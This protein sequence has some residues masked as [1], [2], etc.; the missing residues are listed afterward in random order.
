MSNPCP[1]PSCGHEAP[2]SAKFCPTC[3][4]RF[5][6]CGQC[7]SI[8][9]TLAKFCRRCGKPIG[10]SSEWPSTR[11]DYEFTAYVPFSTEFDA[12][13]AGDAL[14]APWPA[15]AGPAGHVYTSPVS[16]HGLLII[17][18]SKGQVTVMNRYQGGVLAEFPIGGDGQEQEYS[19]LVAE[20]LLV[21][22]GHRFVTAY[23]LLHSFKGWE[24]GGPFRMS[25]EWAYLLPPRERIRRS[26][27]RVSAGDGAGK[28][29]LFST[30]NGSERRV[31][32]IS[33]EHG[34][35]LWRDPIAVPA[36]FSAPVSGE[37]SWAYAVG[38]DDRVHSIDIAAGTLKS[39]IP[40]A[41]PPDLNLAPVRQG[42]RLFFFDKE[43][44]L[45]TCA[46][47]SGASGVPTRASEAKLQVVTGFAVGPLGILVSCSRGLA[48][49]SFTGRPLWTGEGG[50]DAGGSAPVIAGDIGLGI[51]QNRNILYVCDV[52][53]S[54]PRYRQFQIETGQ[55]VAGPAFVDGVLYTCSLDG[56]V[57]SARIQTE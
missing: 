44:A 40:L 7:H 14:P 43:G 19:A 28:A 57:S 16:A 27:N 3:L 42:D 35:P 8:N 20:H 48:M 15:Q 56:R 39:S 45:V 52:R 55:M 41:V 34:T 26:I 4:K 9:R 31:H 30:E 11:G 47:G 38:E 46:V 32:A 53:A 49:L 54:S 6:L 21:V 22:A 36:A 25:Q 10:S 18:S 1:Y 17:C 51:A 29:I 23:N 33:E 5:A 2:D 13:A 24:G 37:G 50:M 12:L